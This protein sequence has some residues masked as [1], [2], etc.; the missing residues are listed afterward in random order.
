[1]GAAGREA[2]CVCVLVCGAR[3]VRGSALLTEL[4]P[5][6]LGFAELPQAFPV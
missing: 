6:L 1:M 4:L 3:S 5:F 2:A